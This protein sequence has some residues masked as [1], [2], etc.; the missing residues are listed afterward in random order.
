[1]HHYFKETVPVALTTEKERSYQVLLWSHWKTKSAVY[2]KE[3]A[4]TK[5]VIVNTLI[6]IKEIVANNKIISSKK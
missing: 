6:R 1:M 2:V 4:G 5:A 3:N